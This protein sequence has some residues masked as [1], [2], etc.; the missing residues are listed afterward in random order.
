MNKKTI[1]EHR[2]QMFEIFPPK[3]ITVKE[4]EREKNLILLATLAP[5]QLAGIENFEKRTKLEKLSISDEL[6]IPTLI[7]GTIVADQT[8]SRQELDYAIMLAQGNHFVDDKEVQMLIGNK[9]MFEAPFKNYSNLGSIEYFDGIEAVGMSLELYLDYF[10]IEDNSLIGWKIKM[11][12]E[13]FGE[14]DASPCNLQNQELILRCVRALSE[15][16]SPNSESITN[17]L[18]QLQAQNKVSD[19]TIYYIADTVK[20]MEADAKM[21]NIKHPLPKMLRHSSVMNIPPF[22]TF[23]Q[24]INEWNLITYQNDVI[25]YLLKLN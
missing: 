15:R 2:L 16:N 11:L 19:K 14:E 20:L 24:G 10:N 22:N 4:L 13:F 8:F 7:E 17:Y 12:K 3:N 9:T 23:I 5:S 25:D 18:L 21:M 6:F 1:L